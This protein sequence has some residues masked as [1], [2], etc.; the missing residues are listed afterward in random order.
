[1]KKFI[2][3]IVFCFVVISANAQVSKPSAGDM[4]FELNA[5]GLSTIRANL[6]DTYG[7]VMVRVFKSETRA[8]RYTA[9][10]A[11]YI[12]DEFTLSHMHFNYG[13][14]NHRQGTERMSPYWGYD[15]GFFGFESDEVVLL[16]NAGLFTGFD[17][18][19]GD[20]LYLGT[21]MGLRMF[22]DL[23]PFEVV[24]SGTVINASL[25]FGYRF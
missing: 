6:N 4:Y 22:V 21:E 19:I 2:F 14:E 8:N 20:G 25:R 7:G 24:L 16:L 3:T 10:L 18:I 1:M 13:I 5:S 23:D 15:F 17:Y 9:N 12:H 11:F